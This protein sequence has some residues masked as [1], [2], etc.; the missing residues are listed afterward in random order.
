MNI[1]RVVKMV[2]AEQQ[3]NPASTDDLA[4]KLE[5]ATFEL[6]HAANQL[7]YS[8]DDVRNGAASGSPRLNNWT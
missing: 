6:R 7:E 2:L 8:A 4:E 3:Q 1:E 5:H